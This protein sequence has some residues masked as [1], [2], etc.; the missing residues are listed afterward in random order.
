MK[1]RILF[2]VCLPLLLAACASTTTQSW[3][4]RIG[5]CTYE[6][7]VAELGEPIGDLKRNDGTRE[8]TWLV[9]WGSHGA[10]FSRAGDPAY[11]ASAAPPLQSEFPA[12]PDRYLHL[13]FGPDGQLK[14][15]EDDRRPAR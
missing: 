15:W 12:R 6:Q 4:H 1:A 10:G 7:A 14:S 3:D 2:C 13:Y 9:E 5:S 11:R 8:V